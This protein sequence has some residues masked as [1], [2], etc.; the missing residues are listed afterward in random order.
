[1]VLACRPSDLSPV[2]AVL[3]GTAPM[4]FTFGPAGGFIYSI[5]LRLADL[6]MEL[7]PCSP[8][9]EYIWQLLPQA[10][11]PLPQVPGRL[12]R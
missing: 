8:E 7:I 6:P 5:Y 9:D 3:F 12:A 10:L 4:T 11:A 1:M 2:S